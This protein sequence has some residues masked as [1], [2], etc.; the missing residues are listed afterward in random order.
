MERQPREAALVLRASPRGPEPRR[1]TQYEMLLSSSCLVE[2]MVTGAQRS[3]EAS[4]ER[5]RDC[6]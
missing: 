3:I 1:I 4:G 2:L 6:F 5:A